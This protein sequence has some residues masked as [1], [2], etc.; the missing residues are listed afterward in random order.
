MDNFSFAFNGLFATTDQFSVFSTAEALPI[1][2]D[3][4]RDQEQTLH[5]FQP[6]V[7]VFAR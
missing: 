6:A 7:E 2:W 4:S 5:P 1:P 3:I